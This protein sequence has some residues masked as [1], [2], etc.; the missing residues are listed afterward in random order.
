MEETRPD[1]SQV[2]RASWRGGTVGLAVALALVALLVVWMASTIHRPAGLLW[3]MALFFVVVAVLLLRPVLSSTPVLSVGPLGVSGQLT[4]GHTVPWSEITDVQ[5]QT[6]QGQQLITLVLRAGSPLLVPTKPLIGG[7]LKRGLSLMPLR[8]AERALAADAVLQTFYR[9]AGAQAQVAA[10]AA[11][12]EL[13]THDAFERRLLE[14]TP[15][16]WALYLVVALN[17]GVWLANLVDGMNPLQPATADLFRWGA[18]SASAVVRDGEHWRL[19]T[20][21]L[22]HGGLLHLALNMWAL[23]V[24]GTQVCR[25]FGNGQFLLIYWGSA[26][27]GSALSLHFSAQQSVSVGASGAVFGVLGALLAGVWQHRERVPKALVN[28][29]LTSQGLFVAISL[30]QGF[31]RPGIDNAAHVGGLLAGAVM[32]WLLV[33]LVDEQASAAHRR[34][35]Q[36]L[37]TAVAALAVGG[38]VGAAQPGV[39]HRALFETQTVLREVLPRFQAAEQALQSDARAQQQGRLSEAQLVEAMERRHIPAYLAVGE[40]MARLSPATPSPQLDDLRGLQ[41]GVLELMTLEVGKARG[42]V[43][44]LQADQRGAVVSAQLAELSQRMRARSGDGG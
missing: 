12:D 39:D 10:Q 28:Q 26:L 34:G 13:L 40:A 35:R 20:A 9:H 17:V 42:T 38:L 43:D 1:G 21:T 3:S 14:K 16:P 27:A 32:A 25:W 23:W 2:F 30:G 24:A 15:H 8:K 5:Q 22:L 7:G 11:M 4:R 36:W 41:S 33:E 31:T 19:I 44:A 37:A 18:S 6:V 29:L